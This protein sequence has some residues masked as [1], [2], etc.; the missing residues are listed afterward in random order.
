MTQDIC[1]GGIGKVVSWQALR[2]FL[3]FFDFLL[4][5][6]SKKKSTIFRPSAILFTFYMLWPYDVVT[7]Y[8]NYNYTN[9]RLSMNMRL[10]CCQLLLFGVNGL[11]S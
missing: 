3:R 1:G 7:F 4:S 10:H 5:V 6:F 8:A 9:A 11:I 2:D